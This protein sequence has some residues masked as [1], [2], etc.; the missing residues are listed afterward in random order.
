M[1]RDI[2]TL[3]KIV[4]ELLKLADIPQVAAKVDILKQVDCEDFNDQALNSRQIEFVKKVITHIEQN[5]YFED[6][7]I[8]GKPPF[9]KPARLMDFDVMRRKRLV[10]VIE[11]VKGN[12]LVIRNL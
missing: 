10:E 2:T 7:S 11:E 4:R 3:V 12:A 1:K 6:L 5:G 8:L 9:D